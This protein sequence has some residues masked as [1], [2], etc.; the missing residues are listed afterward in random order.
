[1]AQRPGLG[2]LR[3]LMESASKSMGVGVG[4]GGGAVKEAATMRTF[5]SSWGVEINR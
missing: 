2:V 3:R 5:S 4:E 1:M